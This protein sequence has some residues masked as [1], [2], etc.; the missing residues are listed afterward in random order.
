M[1]E[2]PFKG[3]IDLKQWLNE[4]RVPAGTLVDYRG[5]SIEVNGLSYK[6]SED[7][8]LHSLQKAHLNNEL[9]LYKPIES[10]SIRWNH[11]DREQTWSPIEGTKKRNDL[12]PVYM[13]WKQAISKGR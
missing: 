1:Q 5:K 10:Y 2:I 13:Q 7:L 12:P 4:H 9:N 6:A 8:G 3:R 11:N